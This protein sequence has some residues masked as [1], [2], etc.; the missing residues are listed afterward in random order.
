M[1]PA[2]TPQP[3]FDPALTALHISSR[4]LDSL[5]RRVA[6]E[7]RQR[8]S[9]VVVLSLLIIAFGTLDLFLWQWDATWH[10]PIINIVFDIV[11]MTVPILI[12]V[13]AGN[14]DIALIV[15][16]V[17]ASLQFAVQYYFSHELLQL[18]Y[19]AAGPLI[20]TLF[21]GRHAGV[22]S[23]VVAAFAIIILTGLPLVSDHPV[24][25]SRP[26][27]IESLTII[28]VASVTTLAA[29]WVVTLQIRSEQRR[30]EAEHHARDTERLRSLG[31]FAGGI[32]HDFNNLLTASRVYAEMLDESD[33]RTGILEATDRATELTSQLLTLGRRQPA[34]CEPTPLHDVIRENRTA[35]ERILGING[36]LILRLDAPQNWAFCDASQFQQILL[37]LA[38]NAR[39]AMRDH[40]SLTIATKIVD[41]ASITK[42][43]PQDRGLEITVVDTGTG[44]SDDVLRRA[45]EPFYTTKEKG[46]GTGL[47]LPMVYSAVERF[48]GHMAI[49]SKLGVGTTVRIV[50]PLVEGQPESSRIA[51]EDD[52]SSASVLTPMSILL[53]D[54][55]SHVVRVT[56][57]LLERMGHTVRS[58]RSSVDAL[59]LSHVENFDVL[60]TDQIMPSVRGFDLARQFRHDSMTI[61]IIIM[62]GYQDNP[63]DQRQLQSIRAVYL[64]K[65][66]SSRQLSRSLRQASDMVG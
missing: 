46:L 6:A 60:I 53:V 39:H 17:V 30:L 16:V 57:A 32:A 12:V 34:A 45:L 24:P 43:H 31:E 40:Q 7:D 23:L 15:A 37:N 28:F 22:V 11:L 9:A 3:A 14:V 44:M 20:V 27:P 4:Q 66:F 5:L 26:L 48:G 59:E 41:D 25:P 35:I 47:G 29:M 10:R 56:Q 8:A 64:Q 62:S 2:P 38:T 52:S 65:P 54:D 36:S 21:V 63:L 33:A 13:L 42:M 55:N 49:E 61:K 18:S 50:L 19:I 51:P 1:G 58:Y